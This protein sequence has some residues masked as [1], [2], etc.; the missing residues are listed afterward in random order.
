MFTNALH[1]FNPLV[2]LLFRDMDKWCEYSCDEEITRKLSHAKMK[3]YAM[4]ILNTVTPGK[5]P[6][7]Y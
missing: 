6:K 7:Y 3:N 1:W 2:Y 5:T 4:A